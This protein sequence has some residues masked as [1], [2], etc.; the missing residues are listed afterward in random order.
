M[1]STLISPWTTEGGTAVRAGTRIDATDEM[2]EAVEDAA[3]AEGQTGTPVTGGRTVR[4]EGV[5]KTK[6]EVGEENPVSGTVAEAMLVEVGAIS[7]GSIRS[8]EK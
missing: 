7:G 8:Q 3:E 5:A 6:A 2:T 1:S 4:T